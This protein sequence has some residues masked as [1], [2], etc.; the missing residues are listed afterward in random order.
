MEYP[1]FPV[2]YLLKHHFD[3]SFYA[4]LRPNRVL[5][6]YGGA[7]TV[8]LNEHTK[9]LMLS[10]NGEKEAHFFPLADHETIM[11]EATLNPLIEDFLEKK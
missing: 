10:W 6:L 3:S 8:I 9:N 5:I 2:R 4:S 1:F 11:K 7:D